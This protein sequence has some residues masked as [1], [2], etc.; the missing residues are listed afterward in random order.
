MAVSVE[1]VVKVTVAVMVMS[2]ADVGV[3]LLW[4][5]GYLL[6]IALSSSLA[7]ARLTC[8]DCNTL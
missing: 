4:L 3:V 6:I 1:M 2:K 8:V 5:L 7:I